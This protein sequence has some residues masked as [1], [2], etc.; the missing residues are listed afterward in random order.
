MLNT[1]TIAETIGATVRRHR[2]KRGWSLNELARRLG[3]HRQNVWR[4]ENGGHTP[5]LATCI[6]Y[7]EAFGLTLPGF[8]RDLE[9]VRKESA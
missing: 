4:L 1:E 8:F 6:E 9:A 2:E 5:T 3:V 7:A